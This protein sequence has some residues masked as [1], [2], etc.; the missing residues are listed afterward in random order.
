MLRDF[1]LGAGRTV[2]KQ[3]AHALRKPLDV[4]SIKFCAAPGFALATTGTRIDIGQ[5]LRFGPRQGR[6]LDQNALSF[7]SVSSTAPFQDNGRKRGVISRSTG[8][9]RVP[10]LQEDEVVEVGTG[11]AQGTL[12]PGEGDPCAATQRL[13]T[14]VARRFAGRNEYLQVLLFAHRRT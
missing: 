11:K 10:R 5:A 13:A 7:I 8:K 14:F 6:F 1:L 3:F 4:L 9:R 2:R 12:F